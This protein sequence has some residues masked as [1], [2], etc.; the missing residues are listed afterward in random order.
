MGNLIHAAAILAYSPN[1][2]VRCGLRRYRLTKRQDSAI[3]WRRK[4]AVESFGNAAEAIGPIEAGM[5]VFA[6]TRG[7]YSMIDCLHHV[8]N[9][10]GPCHLSIWTW[11][12][13]D[14]EVQ[15]LSL[16]HI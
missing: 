7:Q 5:S 4:R 13:A 2:A 15:A 11:A 6:L 10:L 9:E 16:I 1:L 12:I 8:V 3:A 14:Y